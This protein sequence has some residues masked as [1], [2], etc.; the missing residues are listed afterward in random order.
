MKP[1]PPGYLA[2]CEMTDEVVRQ[3]RAS[4]P[5]FRF[6]RREVA[7]VA[8]IA[9]VGETLAENEAARALIATLILETRRRNLDDFPT[10]MML[11]VALEANGLPIRWVPFEELGF[12][13]PPGRQ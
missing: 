11:R 12:A 8:S 13:V 4:G 1:V 6:P 7:L 3:R 2:A 9:D 10:T 5:K